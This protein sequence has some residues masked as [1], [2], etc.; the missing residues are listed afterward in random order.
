MAVS[1]HIEERIKNV[2][3]LNRI[4]LMRSLLNIQR[5]H[6]IKDEDMLAVLEKVAPG[7]TPASL[8]EGKMQGD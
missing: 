1:E 7:I 5:V 8:W 2:I 3:S 6:V 4:S